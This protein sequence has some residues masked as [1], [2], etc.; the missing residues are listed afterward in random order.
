MVEPLFVLGEAVVAGLGRLERRLLSK[1]RR[2]AVSL[3]VR[4]EA[5]GVEEVSLKR[6]EIICRQGQRILHQISILEHILPRVGFLHLINLASY[7]IL[8]TDHFQHAG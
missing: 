1:C 3:C 7:S 8:L 5:L 2:R 6:R 4:K